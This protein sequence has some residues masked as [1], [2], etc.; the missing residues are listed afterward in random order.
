[1][2]GLG[3]RA[4]RVG[5]LGLRAST[6]ARLS[7]HALMAPPHFEGSVDGGTS[8]A[9][10]TCGFQ[11]PLVQGFERPERVGDLVHGVAGSRAVPCDVR[12]EPEKFLGGLESPLSR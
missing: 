10:R 12:G 8:C 6:C 5:V 11:R 3:F 7:T 2:Q 1:M 9:Q 4:F